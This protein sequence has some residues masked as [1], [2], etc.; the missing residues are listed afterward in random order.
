MDAPVSDERAQIIADACSFDAMKKAKTQGN[1][2][3]AKMAAGLMRKGDIMD[4]LFG[5][6]LVFCKKLFLRF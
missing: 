6:H 2:M 5:F 1:G 3:E 4:A